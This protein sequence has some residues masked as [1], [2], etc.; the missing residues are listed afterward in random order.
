MSI[1]AALHDETGWLIECDDAVR[2][3]VARATRKGTHYITSPG[4]HGIRMQAGYWMDR[5]EPEWRISSEAYYRLPRRERA[6]MELKEQIAVWGLRKT[7]E[8]L[9]RAYRS[10][11]TK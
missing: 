5:P 2:V 9:R 8:G 11:P 3:N 6:L 1:I 4:P 10:L 7:F